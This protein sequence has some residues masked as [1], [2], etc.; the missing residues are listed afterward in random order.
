[1]LKKQ[2]ARWR[3]L[4][5]FNLSWPQGMLLTF[6]THTSDGQL[7]SCST[8]KHQIVHRGHTRRIRPACLPN[9]VSVLMKVPR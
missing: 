9:H 5:A 4:A 3:G 8:Q 6:F 7:K 1:G 2:P